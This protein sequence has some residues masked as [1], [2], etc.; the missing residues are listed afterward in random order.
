MQALLRFASES[1]VVLTLV[2][3]RPQD[4]PYTPFIRSVVLQPGF[5]VRGRIE[6]VMSAGDVVV[7]TDKALAAAAGQKKA[8]ALSPREGHEL[9]GLLAQSLPRNRVVTPQAA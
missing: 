6:G 5:E 7:T 8:T 4:W 9:A 2:A 3:S 1:R